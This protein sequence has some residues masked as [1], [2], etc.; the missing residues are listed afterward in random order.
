MATTRP[1]MQLGIGDLE[2]IF[3]RQGKNFAMLSRLKQELSHRQVPRAIAL[4]E[5]VQ[6]AEAALRNMD[7]HRLDAQAPRSTLRLTPGT[8]ETAP[9]QAPTQETPWQPVPT[10]VLVAAPS[11]QDLLAGFGQPTPGS[12]SKEPASGT[13]AQTTAPKKPVTAEP[14]AI[15]QLALEDAYRILKVAAGD[16]WEKVENAR[17]KIVLKSSPLV[18]G[19]MPSSQVQKLL[20]DARLANDAAIVIAARR[21]G[22]Q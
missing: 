13:V 17:R 15:P 22:R 21:S 3:E 11:Q 2:D 1:L 9:A 12:S 18:V 6:K 7:A 19:N 8:P 5:R 16:A 20:A 14:E 10:P 4:L